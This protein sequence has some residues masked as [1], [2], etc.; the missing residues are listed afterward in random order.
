[1]KLEH[2]KTLQEFLYPHLATLP[3]CFE[4]CF[5][6]TKE[7]LENTHAHNNREINANQCHL[8]HFLRNNC[9]IYD[10]YRIVRH[11]LLANTEWNDLENCEG[12]QSKCFKRHVSPH[13]T[14]NNHTSAKSSRRSTREDSLRIWPIDFR[15]RR[16]QLAIEPLCIL[17]T[18]G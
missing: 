15:F 3:L 13:Q 8:H 10:V 11:Y 4:C 2:E 9:G 18:S 17:K 16:W 7:A 14:P 1:M 5:D 12:S 6:L